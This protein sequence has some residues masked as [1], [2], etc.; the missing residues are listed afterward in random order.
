MAGA[1]VI[2]LW[3]AV[4]S[5]A[6]YLASSA[7]GDILH[8]RDGSKFSGRL[9]AETREDYLFRLDAAGDRP[10]EIRKFP[11]D[12]VERL[13]RGDTVEPKADDSDQQ[14]DDVPPQADYDQW[15][16][17]AF[18]LID[19]GEMRPGVRVLSQL[20]R[21]KDRATLARLDA[22]CRAGKQQPL[23]E[24]LAAKR[25]ELATSEPGAIKFTGVTEYE[26][27]ALGR[28]LEARENDLLTHAFE[29]RTIRQWTVKQNEMTKAT[30]D[31]PA[32]V[33]DARL[34]AAFLAAR[35]KYDPRLRTDREIRAA[36]V[37][38]HDELA[39]LV[40]RVAALPG[41]NTDA[42][43]HPSAA[44]YGPPYKPEPR[45]GRE[46]YGTGDASSTTQP[47]RGAR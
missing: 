43:N 3:T 27:A 23:A 30:S 44:D 37:T 40:A 5:L 13:E 14:P 1:R 41:Y 9:I 33:R 10:A 25:I 6:L 47:A 31:S 15:L 38:L 42:A 32:L 24:F 28:L 21:L 39:R 7:R 36:L 17:E 19:R 8:L 11:R 34:A 22:A 35:L 20:A 12:A 29:G 16:R 46:L 26:S 18:E 45:D 2:P 4:A